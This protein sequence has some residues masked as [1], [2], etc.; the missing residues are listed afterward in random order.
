MQWRGQ[1]QCLPSGRATENFSSAARLRNVRCRLPSRVC[2]DASLGNLM[3]RLSASAMMS[4]IRDTC[5]QSP[6]PH[7]HADCLHLVCCCALTCSLS[8]A[9]QDS[10]LNL[11]CNSS[12]T[13]FP[14]AHHTQASPSS[15]KHDLV[16]SAL[17]LSCATLCIVPGRRLTWVFISS[18][19]GLSPFI[20]ALSAE[21][22]RSMPD[23]CPILPRKAADRPTARAL[24]RSSQAGAS[25]AGKELNKFRRSHNHIQACSQK[26]QTRSSRPAGPGSTYKFS[27]D[28]AE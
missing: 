15:R 21:R 17:C 9:A 13:A 25:P 12:C 5:T 3:Y 1:Q 6:P 18:R 27:A 16:L 10:L 8:I 28:D 14:P 26:L 7:L 23:G 24:W 19:M 20:A 11:F 4:A 22:C 2:M